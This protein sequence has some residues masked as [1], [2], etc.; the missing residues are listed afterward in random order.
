MIQDRDLFD[1][2]GEIFQCR[3]KSE[4]LQQRLDLGRKNNHASAF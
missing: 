4:L 2:L 3:E 1:W